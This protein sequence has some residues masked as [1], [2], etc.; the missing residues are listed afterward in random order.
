MQVVSFFLTWTVGRIASFK[1]YIIF[2]MRTRVIVFVKYK[3]KLNI[4]VGM[5]FYEKIKKIHGVALNKIE[6]VLWLL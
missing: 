4:E 6:Y 1:K 3:I 5:C 2:K